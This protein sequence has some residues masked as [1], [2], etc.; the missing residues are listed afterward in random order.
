[1]NIFPASLVADQTA[2]GNGTAVTGAPLATLIQG[3]PD[4][5]HPA[6]PL[7]VCTSVVV[8][9]GLAAGTVQLQVSS[10]GST[11]VNAGLAASYTYTG[12]TVGVALAIAP[13]SNFLAVPGTG[14]TVTHIRAVTAGITGTIGRITTVARTEFI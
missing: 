9:T 5:K 2:V 3:G 8:G 12:G 11:F 6:G 14:A 4:Y 13:L 10:D 7:V 1:M